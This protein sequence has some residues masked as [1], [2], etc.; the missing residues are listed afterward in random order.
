MLFFGPYVWLPA[1]TYAFSLDGEI[2]GALDLAM[3]AEK[4]ERKLARV[5][6]ASFDEPIVV[7]LPEAMNGFEIVGHRT[8]SLERLV[9]RGAIV[10]YRAHSLDPAQKATPRRARGPAGDEAR[11]CGG[12]LVA[13]VTSE[14]AAPAPV[15]G[16][17]D[18]GKPVSFPYTIPAD[19]MRVHDAYNAG[20]DSISAVRFN[21]RLSNEGPWPGRGVHPVLWALPEPRARRLHD[22]NQ[23][24]SRRS[25]L[26]SPDAEV[27]LGAP[28]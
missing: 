28:P 12:S 25:P 8:P 6:V 1:G 23:R 18:D 10:E 14:P 4:G 2:S 24:G 9:L 19:G 15:Y 11:G 5:I 21:D 3:T 17:D 13:P 22:P 16:R 20:A 27:C 7:D 26:R